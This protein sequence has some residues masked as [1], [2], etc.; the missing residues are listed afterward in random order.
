MSGPKRT[1]VDRTHRQ[2]FKPETVE[3]FRRA[4]EL[5]DAPDDTPEHAEWVQV[6]K[7]LNWRMLKLPAHCCEVEDPALDGACFMP[8]GCAMAMDW[9]RCQRLRRALLEAAE[10]DLPER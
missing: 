6:T 5:F 9:A 10:Y 8:P 4:C 1:I 7:L 2:K 3:A